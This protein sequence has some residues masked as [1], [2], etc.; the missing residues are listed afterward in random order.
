MIGKI[1][2][3]LII[4]AV[5]CVGGF[6]FYSKVYIPK[7]TYKTT[8]PL[9]GEIKVRVF[10]IGNEGAKNIYSINAGVSGKILSILSDEGKWVKKGDLLVVMDEVDLPELLKEAKLGVDKAKS[11]LVASQ[12]ELKGLLAQKSLAFVTFERYKK[13]KKQS[14]ASQAEYDKA[15]SDL[16]QIKAQIEVTK[17][18][19]NS[20]RTGI[21]IAQKAVDAL[22]IKISRYKIYSPVSGFVISKNVEVHQDV[23]PN[24]AILKIVDPK[25]V[26]IKTYI[27]EKIS[28]DIK[29]GQ[30]A[31]ITLRSQKDKK[32]N[33][34]VKRIVAQSDAVTL[35]REV[36]VAFDKVPIPFYINEQAEV[37]IVT[38]QFKNL[39]KVPSNLIVYK[40]EKPGIWIAKGDKAYFQTIKIIARG[41]KYTGVAGLD[42]DAKLLLVTPKNK[43]LKEGM[44]IHL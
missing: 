11:T 17:A 25:T 41:E 20:A 37:V 12:K 8:S 3:Y 36:D 2:K 31:T 32:L 4:I 14:F 39:I 24:Q 33:G 7:T 30:K 18:H 29:V 23:L 44:R 34:Y 42:K 26:W 6:L 15:K 9:Q 27:D 43:P 5:L 22:Q 13:L 28:G 10:G 38:K 1:V 35:E 21:K 40:N 19:I 16:S